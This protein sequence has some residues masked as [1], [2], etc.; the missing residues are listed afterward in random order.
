MVEWKREGMREGESVRVRQRYGSGCGRNRSLRAVAQKWRP[1]KSNVNCIE[2]TCTHAYT[3]GSHGSHAHTKGLA[4][5]L[6][7]RKHTHPT[8]LCGIFLYLFT[9]IGFQCV[10]HTVQTVS[11]KDGGVGQVPFPLPH[12]PSP[13]HLSLCKTHFRPDQAQLAKRKRQKGNMYVIYHSLCELSLISFRM[14]LCL[15][16]CRVKQIN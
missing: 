15:G 12:S 11:Y 14:F 2:G 4:F 9:L 6:N 7:K 1:H 5:T 8:V 10:C 16:I 3:H 13:L